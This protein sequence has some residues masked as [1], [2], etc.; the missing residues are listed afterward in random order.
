MIG[1]TG[2]DFLK[3]SLSAG[4]GVA[5]LSTLHVGGESLL[6]IFSFS[7]FR[8][9]FSV[10]VLSLPTNSNPKINVEIF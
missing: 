2:G 6:S 3:K 9:P 1:A 8:S 5:E 4:G 10:F 7:A